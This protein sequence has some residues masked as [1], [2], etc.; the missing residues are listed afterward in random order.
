MFLS[1][2]LTLCRSAMS[3]YSIFY[4]LSHFYRKYL[5]QET[6][7]IM[8]RGSLG[9]GPPD[10]GS[11]QTSCPLIHRYFV[12]NP[13]DIYSTLTWFHVSDMCLGD[14]AL[15]HVSGARLPWGKRRPALFP[16]PLPPGWA[17]PA[18]L[19][20]CPGQRWVWGLEDSGQSRGWNSGAGAP[21]SSG[22]CPRLR[23]GRQQGAA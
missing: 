4:T 13:R 9:H 20:P 7:M 12:S 14:E 18:G 11:D 15:G 10:T 23:R 16:S 1:V 22:C 21:S 5:K 17:R 8:M 6:Y 19:A 3:V 2:S